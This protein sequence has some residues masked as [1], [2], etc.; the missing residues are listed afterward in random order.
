MISHP[1]KE[2][3]R[4]AHPG[5]LALGIVLLIVVAV[6]F[7]R[8]RSPAV[9]SLPPVKT[10][11]VVLVPGASLEDWQNRQEMPTLAACA[12]GVPSASGS[13]GFIGVFPN[14]LPWRTGSEKVTVLNPATTADFARA[15][16][17]LGGEPIKTALRDAAVASVPLGGD[18]AA[19]AFLDSAPPSAAMDE[20]QEWRIHRPEAVDGFVT[21]PMRLAGAI[22]RESARPL[23]TPRLI[24]VSFDDLL[25][26]DAYAPLTRPTAA[27]SERRAALRRLDALFAQLIGSG[28]NCVP[29][30]T[31]LV[32]TADSYGEPR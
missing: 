3:R 5:L 26:C 31:A 32:V 14:R 18:P 6:L 9:H 24:T 15:C 28:P 10:V 29:A 16:K 11:I 1:V 23:L 25:R 12:G 30:D 2:P 4:S 20:T 7:S 8:L 27:A 17:L 22:R 21:D 19:S 13:R